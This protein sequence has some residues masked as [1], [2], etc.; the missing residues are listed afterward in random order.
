MKGQDKLH[1]L[2]HS[3]S[4]SERR[5]F[6][7]YIS[8]FVQTE[9]VYSLK[10]YNTITKQKEYDEEKLY[11]KLKLKIDKKRLAVEKFNLFELILDAL[12][13]YYNKSYIDIEL[14]KAIQKIQILCI[15]GLLE[16]A[17]QQIEKY[18][19]IAYKSDN[20]FGL[21]HLLKLE[22]E[23]VPSIVPI[24]QLD[25]ITQ[26]LIGE[27]QDKLANL[28][29]I[30]SIGRISSAYNKVV[31]NTNSRNPKIVSLLKKIEDAHPLLTDMQHLQSIFAIHCTYRIR[32]NIA[33]HCKEYP[34]MQS[35]AE[36]VI[37]FFEK[38]NERFNNQLTDYYYYPKILSIYLMTFLYGDLDGKKDRKIVEGLQKLKAIPKKFGSSSKIHSTIHQQVS[39]GM[40]I[41]LQYYI[42]RNQKDAVLEMIEEILAYGIPDEKTIRYTNRDDVLVLHFLSVAYFYLKEYD[43][44]WEYSN[45]V[46]AVLNNKTILNLTTPVLVFNL[47][48]HYELGNYQLLEYQ[49]DK[50]Y[51]K[52]QKID[53]SF[54]WEMSLIKQLKKMIAYPKTSSQIGIYFDELEVLS[55]QLFQSPFEKEANIYFNYL[56]WIQQNRQFYSLR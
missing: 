49:L 2:I 34:K 38:E 27:A 51:Y 46:I 44:A 56:L 31:I 48:V 12:N 18:K 43:K 22:M 25:N 53:G 47:I 16:Q 3:L 6:K 33:L 54:Q 24:Q 41:V 9:K 26:N 7:L 19:K 32:C 23:L 10:L 52:I 35:I 55:Q 5:Y 40:A 4:S 42:L 15:K 14:M 1:Q 30:Y 45:S 17:Q 29:E 11:K 36:E 20:H 50:V 39:K 21:L 28:A 8:R 37:L 13:N